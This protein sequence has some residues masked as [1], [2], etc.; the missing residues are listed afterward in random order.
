MVASNVGG[1][2]LQVIDGVNGYLLSPMDIE[3]FA[4]KIVLLLKHPNLRSQLGKNGIQHV[5]QNFLITRLMLDWLNIFESY[6]LEKK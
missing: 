2:A 3:G 1:I 6:L 5:K 4:K